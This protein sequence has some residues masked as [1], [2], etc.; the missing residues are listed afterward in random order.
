MLWLLR[1]LSRMGPVEVAHRVGE[2]GKR[3]SDRRRNWGWGAFEP[4]PG[5]VCG[6]PGLE[7]EAAGPAMREEANAQFARLRGGNLHWLGQDWPTVGPDWTH[8]IWT[9][10]PVTGC[11]WPGAGQP[12]ASYRDAD[13]RGDVK[14]VWEPNRLQMLHPLALLAAAGDREAA[15]FAFGILEGWM[16]ANPP[17]D[18]INWSSGIEA[19][20]RVVS[21]LVLQA[22]AGSFAT[23]D[24]ACRLRAFLQAHARQLARYPSL[25]SSAN[26]HRI[27]ELGAL[28][29]LRICAPGLDDSGAVKSDLLAELEREV[30]RQFHAD[31][32]GAEQSP[33]YAAY[34]LEWFLLA[35]AAAE[36]AGL[37]V[38]ETWR[39]QVAAAA[40]HLL[41]LLDEYGRPPRIGDDDE[42]RVLALRLE[43]ETRY[44]ASVAAAVLRWLGRLQPSAALRDLDLRD[45]LLPVAD[46]APP[47]PSP[48]GDRTFGGGGYTV[49][50]TAT[51]QGTAVLT[52]DHGPLGFLSIAAHGHADALA[53]W[54]SLGD[55]P[56]LVD[57]G[58]YLYHA[59]GPLR[60]RFR[61]TPAHNTLSIEGADQ[62]RIFGP[63][64]WGAHACARLERR[65]RFGVAALHD[66]W[67]SRF[68]LT[69]TRCVD[70][71][72][73]G[74]ILIEDRLRGRSRAS[75][76]WAVGFSLAPGSEVH[77]DGGLA[78]IRTAGG[79]ELTM[80]TKDGAWILEEGVYSPAFNRMR[81]LH[82]ISLT[83]HLPAGPVPEIQTVSVRIR[84][85]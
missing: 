73:P 15:A 45:Q 41:W 49:A 53:V 74:E 46:D 85:A 54:L 40:E 67:R 34:S 42:G 57:A 51:R 43:P 77:I 35:G 79:R 13:G 38:S 69:H 58:T 18:G 16:V 52:F 12:G 84:I 75:A 65:D 33:T 7:L 26:N 64:A 5:P 29:L 9:L 19:A 4:F 21:A 60:D 32:V 11:H 2:Q 37:P 25:H 8:S 10:D 78:G 83:G 80:L 76:R 39:S 55:E 20:S 59:G 6:L 31:G 61:G 23:P 1:R 47:M 30:I 70:W 66:G 63:F 17:Y 82:R 22:G 44:P 72:I 3:W 81:S 28:L 50:R 62:S 24:D 36:G 14:F 56:V 71:S 48:L 68:G 27:S